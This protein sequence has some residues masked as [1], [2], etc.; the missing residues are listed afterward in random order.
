MSAKIATMR[1]LL[2]EDDVH[3][4]GVLERGLREEG[5]VV[6]AVGTGEEALDYLRM[7]EYGVCILDWRMPGAS[8]STS[9]L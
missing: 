2:A 7:Y 1:V 4:R 9:S 5:Y 3:L 8:G 6:D